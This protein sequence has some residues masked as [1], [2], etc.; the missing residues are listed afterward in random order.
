MEI[1]EIAG[2]RVGIDVGGTFTDFV[3]FDEHR[4]IRIFKVPSVPADPAAGVLEGA[5]QII[6]AGVSPG[7]INV[8]LHGTTIGL[9]ALLQRS[10]ARIGLL[11]TRGFQ[12]VLR[13]R[14][15]R[16]AGAPGFFVTQPDPLIPRRDIRE[17]GGRL[18]A[19]GREIRPLDRSEVISAVEQL[20]T[21]GCEALAVCFLHSYR[22]PAHEEATAS[23]IRERFPEMHVTMSSAVWPQQ[24]E[25]ERTEISVINAHIA[26]VMERYF[27]RLMDNFGT[28]GIRAPVFSTKSSGGIMSAARASERPVETLLSGPASGIVA[29]AALGRAAGESELIAFDMG[30]TSA[31][32][33][34]VQG[35]EVRTS[36][37]NAIGDFPVIMPAVDVASIGAG[38]GSIAHVDASGVLKVGPASAGADPGPACY[39]RGGTEPTVTDSYV[40]LGMLDPERFLGGELLLDV[41]AARQA[42][43]RIGQRLGIPTEDAAE[44]ILR[45]ATAN[46]F[47]SFLPLMAQRGANPRDF[48]LLAY[49]GAGPTH[50]FYLAREVGFERVLIPASPGTFAALGCLLADV[51]A[52]FVRTVYSPLDKIA[53]HDLIGLF[54]QL[55]DQAISWVEEERV[56]VP[57]SVTFAGDLRYAGQSYEITVAL[58]EPGDDF[59]NRV[60]EAF[61]MSYQ[62]IYGYSDHDAPVELVNARAFVLGTTPKP[63]LRASGGHELNPIG[64]RGVRFEGVEHKTAI[65]DRTTLGPSSAFTGPAMVVQYDTTTFVPPGYSVHVDT[66]GNLV[67]RR[68][69]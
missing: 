15:L 25:Y 14:R 38:G 63:D 46:M 55:R 47:A 59:R 17:I 39:G 67:G 61:N 20:V 52:D 53:D 27:A 44:A 1:A 28:L 31:D 60:V 58:P 21:A 12:D 7:A 66:Y 62:D 16:L 43:G 49:G 57:T 4:G 26:P 18:L 6:G 32:I 34:I 11:T 10:G 64:H 50:A 36:T 22:N 51:R 69:T 45:V 30:G 37:D 24:R 54:E 33:G 23:W 5:R 42:C 8:I 29:A 40:V 2:H 41:E 9:N 35:G 13:L 65:Y 19:D 56:N 3:V 48:A 68:D